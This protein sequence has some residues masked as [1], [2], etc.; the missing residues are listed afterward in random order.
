MFLLKGKYKSYFGG[1]KESS[2]GQQTNGDG[3]G[4]PCLHLGCRT[5]EEQQLRGDTLTLAAGQG[6]RLD[7]FLHPLISE[8]N[9]NLALLA[10][11]RRLEQP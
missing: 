2:M 8:A 10:Q 5:G 3:C 6:S 4:P 9:K 1:I 11:L 7:Q